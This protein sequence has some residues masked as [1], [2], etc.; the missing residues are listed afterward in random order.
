MAQNDEDIDA[1][2]SGQQ[3]KDEAEAVQTIAEDLELQLGTEIISAEARK[4]GA[5]NW[6]AEEQQRII[7]LEQV[8]TTAEYV[9][10]DHHDV[11]EWMKSPHPELEGIPPLEAAMTEAGAQRAK[12]ILNCLLFGLPA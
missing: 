9:L 5:R 2:R 3:P 7:R 10:R 1:L 6:T 12:Y 4:R 11:C 8:F